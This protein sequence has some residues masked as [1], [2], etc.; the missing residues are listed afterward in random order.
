MLVCPVI[1]FN[2]KKILRSRICEQAKPAE[3][4]TPPTGFEPVSRP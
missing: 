3:G 4:K 1:P 2:K